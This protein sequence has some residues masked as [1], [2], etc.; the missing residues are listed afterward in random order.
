MLKRPFI[1]IFAVFLLIG[2]ACVIREKSYEAAKTQTDGQIEGVVFDIVEKSNTT[3]LHLKNCI[4][5]EKAGERSYQAGTVLVYYSNHSKNLSQ[6]DNQ[7]SKQYRNQNPKLVLYEE[8]EAKDEVEIGNTVRV[9]GTLKSF[10]K[11][12]NLGQFD[13]W[14]YYRSREYHYKFYGEELKIINAAS[15]LLKELLRSLRKGFANVYDLHLEQSEA[16][17]IKAMVLGEKSGLEEEIK[18]LYRQN[19]IGHLMAISGLHV[20]LLGMGFYGLLKRVGSPKKLSCVLAI[21]FI[22]LYGLMTGFS[23]STN[24]AV[25]MMMLALT[26]EIV[27]R[28]YDMPTALSIGGIVI[29]AQ[30]PM[31]CMD[32]GFLLSF[33]AIAGVGFLNPLLR[34]MFELG[35]SEK[36]RK[37]VRNFNRQPFKEL[38][39]KSIL[40][41]FS[42]QIATLPIILY[43]YY[44][45]PLYSTIL[46]ILVIPLMSVLLGFALLGGAA[47]LILPGIPLISRFFLGSVH[48]ILKIYEKSGIVVRS[49][50]CSRIIIGKPR[51][52]QIMVYYVLLLALCRVLYLMSA[53]GRGRRIDTVFDK[54]NKLLKRLWKQWTKLSVWGKRGICLLWLTVC[55]GVLI[56]TEKWN[57]KGLEMTFLDVGQGDC[58]FLKN[59]NGMTCLIDGGSSDEKK[60]GTY[61]IIPFLK[62]KGVKALDYVMVTH[63]DSDHMNGITELLEDSESG[64]ILVRNLILPKT[65]LT[66]DNYVELVKLAEENEIPIIYIKAGDK[67][68]DGQLQITCL[69]PSYDFMPENTNSY[70]MVLEV[71]YETFKAL[72]TGD[73]EENGEE[74]LVESESLTDVF[75]LKVAHHGS[76]N[77]TSESF[78]EKTDPELA[79]ISYGENNSYGHPHAET[80]ERLENA[81][82]K[83]MSTA[84]YGGI[85]IRIEKGKVKAYGYGR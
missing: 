4:F 39:T 49:L 15:N 35:K 2:C 36:E 12:R 75:L 40:G 7:N 43:F 11:P 56:P 21:L 51:L 18:N 16:G 47:G 34:E 50:P 1:G 5:Y 22:W 46:N 33:G 9:W 83:V 60:V 55:F 71:E 13:E 58:I 77:S 78:L 74:A 20:S 80:L 64:G 23:L 30:K 59:G 79:I 25:I 32:C 68:L 24:R 63:A 69:H 76:K 81:G 8:N 14:F 44:E 38:V 61:R 57:F 19:G 45:L 29:L 67:L 28:T 41:S 27:G 42:V 37:M 66:E 31:L 48:M 26:A 72:L 62:A 85:T 10:E 6:K 53:L 3:Q 17:V 73:V 70:S 82:S 54:D 84:D 52:W 65:T